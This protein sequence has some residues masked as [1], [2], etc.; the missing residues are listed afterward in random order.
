MQLETIKYSDILRCSGYLPLTS[1]RWRKY[2]GLCNNEN[3]L[4]ENI[5]LNKDPQSNGNYKSDCV[6][7]RIF[8]IHKISCQKNLPT[9]C[10]APKLCDDFERR[11][12]KWTTSYNTV[13]K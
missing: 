1:F 2:Y 11:P 6:E 13:D 3:T 5:G 7:Q 4:E 9:L 12:N 10:F 8:K